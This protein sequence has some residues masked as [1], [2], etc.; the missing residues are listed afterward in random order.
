MGMDLSV[1]LPR[2]GSMGSHPDT[3]TWIWEKAVVRAKVELARSY[4]VKGAT[5]RLHLVAD[6]HIFDKPAHEAEPRLIK[7]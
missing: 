7:S 1:N 5:P 3:D 4:A 6:P 2:K